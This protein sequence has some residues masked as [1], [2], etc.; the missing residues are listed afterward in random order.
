MP[1]LSSSAIARVEYDAASLVMQIWFQGNSQPYSYFGVPDGVY[2]GLI[3]ASS[4]GGF[5]DRYVKD[6][7]S[8]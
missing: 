5:Y 4:A 3:T 2:R 6:R 1:Y 7:Y 8:R